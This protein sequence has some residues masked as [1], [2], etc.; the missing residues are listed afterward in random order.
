MHLNQLLR[1]ADQFEYFCYLC[2]NNYMYPNGAFPHLLGAGAK[3]ILKGTGS[4]DLQRIDQFRKET[5]ASSLLLG[6]LNYNLRTQLENVSNANPS[7]IDAFPLCFFEPE[8]LVY[9][10]KR[11]SWPENISSFSS[12]FSPEKKTGN[13]QQDLS[14][15]EYLERVK[16]LQNHIARGDIYETN[17]CL[18]FSG[19]GILDP[20]SSFLDLMKQSPMPFSAFM[21]TGDLY[22]LC[23]SPERYLQKKGN[24]LLS[25]PIKGTLAQGQNT[26][27]LFSE[28]ERSENIMIVDLVRNDLSKVCEAGS[29]HVSELCGIYEFPGLY[30]MISSVKGTLAQ[31]SSATDAIKTSFPMGSMTG[32]PKVS[33]MELT[34]RYEASARELF[35]GALGY[36]TAE[37]DFDFNVIIRSLFYDQKKQ[38]FT[39]SAGSAITA[40]CKAE[41]EYDE[42]ILKTKAIQ[43]IL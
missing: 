13:I 19:L 34:D 28:K 33:A 4:D 14:R 25:Q 15:E 32:A 29:V 7:R 1:W 42:C 3:R 21:K 41:E 31:S 8:Y 6:Y 43:R 2:P 17:F 27:K 35:S 16:T 37:G 12:S 11:E 24:Q 26:E 30:Q 23:A 5:N 39:Y 10:D 20:V 18:N 9:P 22:I 40:L 38:I 36:I